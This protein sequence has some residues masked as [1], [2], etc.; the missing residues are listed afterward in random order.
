M[1]LVASVVSRHY[2]IPY[3]DTLQAGKIKELHCYCSYEDEVCNF[4]PFGHSGCFGFSKDK[5]DKNCYL[6]PIPGLKIY[7]HQAQIAKHGD[8]FKGTRYYE[9][10][11]NLINEN[12]PET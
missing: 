6:E 9:E 3:T 2:H 7:N 12:N 4:A 11:L 10:W 1:I 8:Y 5:Y